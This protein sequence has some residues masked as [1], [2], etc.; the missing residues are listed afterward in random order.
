MTEEG[1]CA[2]CGGD[3]LG[4]V[5]CSCGRREVDACQDC[6]DCGVTLVCRGCQDRSARAVPGGPYPCPD[7]GADG[8][9]GGWLCP[10]PLPLERKGSRAAPVWRYGRHRAGTT[11]PA[12]AARRVQRRVPWRRLPKAPQRA[13]SSRAALRALR[14]ARVGVQPTAFPAPRPGA[15]ARRRRPA[16]TPCGYGAKASSLPPSLRGQVVT[17]LCVG[18]SADRKPV[19]LAGFRNPAREGRKSAGKC[20]TAKT[21][22]FRVGQNGFIP[23]VRPCTQGGTGCPVSGARV[24]FATRLVGDRPVGRRL[25]LRD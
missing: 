18:G 21:R 7:F 2:G 8:G 1:I 3:C 15:D 6:V 5:E 14:S 23:G 11:R 22:F 4:S 10:R 9:L 16:A 17:T 20:P 12:A 13:A 25:A 24:H 19:W